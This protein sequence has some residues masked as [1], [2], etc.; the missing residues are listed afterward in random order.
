MGD[1]LFGNTIGD[2]FQNNQI[3][4]GFSSNSISNFFSD[5]VIGNQF[6]DNTIADDFGFGGSLE[7]G[8]K[9]G[10]NFIDNT[11]GEYFY[12]NTIG[13]NFELNT[14]GDYFQFNRVET[15]LA[16]IDFTENLGKITGHEGTPGVTGTDGTYSGVTGTTDG[17]GVDAE[18]TL[19]VSTGIV[20]SIENTN[21]GRKYKIGDTITIDPS[22]FGG[23]EPLPIT[24][25]DISA[26]PMVYKYYNKTIQRDTDETVVLVAISS[27]TGLYVS[28]AI[29]APID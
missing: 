26:A 23:T 18:F 5:N 20:N 25:T 24:V 11:I 28:S 16:N 29:T 1:N 3:G 12:D 15:P 2:N 9:I 13:D 27:A 8:N 6:M 22:A 21:Q 17:Q 14:I 7:R 4:N 10:N 19:G